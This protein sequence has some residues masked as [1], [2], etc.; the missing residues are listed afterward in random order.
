MT[1]L[2][3]WTTHDGVEGNGDICPT[4]AYELI[5][6]RTGIGLRRHMSHPEHE[7]AMT[8]LPADLCV[9]R[10]PKCKIR[11]FPVLP[12]TILEVYM[13]GNNL[14]ELP[15]LSAF[16]ELIV[17][18]LADNSIP[19]LDRPLPPTLASLHL[20]INALRAVNHEL[21]PTSCTDVRMECNPMPGLDRL[22]PVTVDDIARVHPLR[23]REDGEEPAAPKNPYENGQSVHNSSIQN[24]THSNIQYLVDYKPDVPLNPDVFK[25]IHK[26]YQRWYTF[27]KGKTPGKILQSFCKDVYTMCGVSMIR[28]VD[29]IWLRIKDTEDIELRN[30]LYDRLDTEVRDGEHHCKNGMMVRLTNVF[31]SFDPNIKLDVSAADAMGARLTASMNHHR[32]RLN[33]KEGEETAVFWKAVYLD[34]V[35]S[36]KALDYGMQPNGSIN[37]SAWHDWLNTISE[38]ILDEIVTTDVLYECVN[39]DV[40]NKVVERPGSFIRFLKAEGLNAY[41]WEIQDMHSRFIKMTPTLAA[42]RGTTDETLCALK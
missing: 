27:G 24:N 29:R 25:D 28:L 13:D 31:A 36:L 32:N 17:L 5:C 33:I 41:A 35:E 15:D 42:R 8:S 16:P 1:T 30:T 19:A 6:V 34:A 12:T 7:A 38:S 26:H 3:R 2:F 22:Y 18:E 14:M 9:L 40:T 21:I 20:N 4:S 11:T 10:A 23:R 37:I 39:P